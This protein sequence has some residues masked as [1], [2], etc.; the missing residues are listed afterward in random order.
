M[1]YCIKAGG[2]YL[3]LYVIVGLPTVGGSGENESP[4]SRSFS[5]AASG[6]PAGSGMGSPAKS[7]SASPAVSG[8]SRS[9]SQSPAR[10]GSGSASPAHSNAGSIDS[11][12][13]KQAVLE[14]RGSPPANDGEGSMVGS[15]VRSRSG[16]L[17]SERSRSPAPDGAHDKSV[18][19]RSASASPARS[20]SRSP[21]RS[22][23][24]SPAQRRSRSVTPGSR[25]ASG[26]PVQN[27]SRSASR[28][29]SGSPARSRSVTP[30]R[31]RSGSPARSRSGSYARSGSGS[32][33]RS[34]SMSRSPSRGSSEHSRSRSGS[35]SPAHS[36]SGR[37][38]SAG[39]Q[40]SGRS[41]ASGASSKS[42]HSTSKIKR[43][44]QDELASGSDAEQPGKPSPSLTCLIQHMHTLTVLIHF[45]DESQLPNWLSI[46]F[47]CLFQNRMI[48]AGF[49]YSCADNQLIIGIG[50]LLALLPIISIGRLVHWYRLIVAYTIGEC[51]Y[52]IMYPWSKSLHSKGEWVTLS[53]DFGGMGRRPLTAVN[54]KRLESLGYHVALFL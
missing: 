11:E 37:R 4:R 24:G 1:L 15:P 5:P 31:S 48:V 18:T 51:F 27:R 53:T 28:S 34:R 10:S 54:V 26:S 46:A 6:S 41:A 22:K 32:P 3:Q 23:S 43:R 13:H 2:S 7:G 25:S 19:P 42:A 35:G 16:S 9:P 17:E 14:S 47:L 44:E 8:H 12:T 52:Y 38:P 49:N 36:R 40:H 29:L 20:L 45:P 33:A 39:S 21:V 50:Q 30:A